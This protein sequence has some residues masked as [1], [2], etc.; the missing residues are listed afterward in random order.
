MK[1]MRNF[2]TLMFAV[3]G[4][5]AAS[6]LWA[7]D[8]YRSD[9]D[10][11]DIIKTSHDWNKAMLNG[12]T[13]A[14]E[15]ILSDDYTFVDSTG[16]TINKQQ[17]IGAYKDGSLKFESITAS[18]TRTRLYVGGAVV[19]GTVSIKAK[20]KT[21]DISGEYRFVEVYEPAKG[22]GWQAVFSQITK[23]PEK[24]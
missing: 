16:N 12:D 24:K 17:E 21:D 7:A 4:L 15:K 1:I 19:S 8:S 3:I 5:A 10:T 14:M 20:Y 2:I 18:S 6:N 13:V 23:V 22:G 11:Q 9:K